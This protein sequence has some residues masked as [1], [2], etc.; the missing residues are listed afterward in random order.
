MNDIYWNLTK[1]KWKA[2]KEIY[3]RT[4]GSVACCVKGQGQQGG[5]SLAPHKLKRIVTANW[6]V[7][8]TY[9]HAHIHAQP[10][11]LSHTHSDT[12]ITSQMTPVKVARV[13]QP[14]SN[15]L[16]Y[17]RLCSPGR[18][19]CANEAMV[20]TNAVPRPGHG[21]VAEETQCARQHHDQR[22]AGTQ[23]EKWWR[24]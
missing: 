6:A 11:T 20:H 2:K 22:H 24:W 17:I 13:N 9:K 1:K 15:D 23:L 21:G 14:V 16:F 3:E 10:Y 4:Q 5:H 12:L 7:T 19:W 8:S 18:G